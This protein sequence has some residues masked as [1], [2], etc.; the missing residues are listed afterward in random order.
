METQLPLEYII[1]ESTKKSK[2]TPVIFMLHGYGSNEQDLFSFANELPEQY[3]IISLRAPYKLSDFGYAWYAIDFDADKGKWSDNKQAIESRD[4]IVNF[5]EEACKAHK[6]DAKNVTLLGFSQGCILSLAVALS[7]PQKI[8][9]VIGLSGY[10]NKDILKQDFEKQNFTGLNIYVSHGASDQIIPVE[11]AR[12]TAPELQR[13]HINFVYEE[14]PVGHG[15]SPQNFYSF[16][17]WLKS[18]S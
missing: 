11:W 6:L 12:A 4:L 1:K 2:N 3:T 14:F 17:D 13:L 18:K 9:N 16:R 8:K 7:Y 5:I 15:V 10:L